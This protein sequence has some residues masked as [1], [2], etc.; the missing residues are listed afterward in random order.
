MSKRIKIGSEKAFLRQGVEIETV[1]TVSDLSFSAVDRAIGYYRDLCYPRLLSAF[2]LTHVILDPVTTQ[3]AQVNPE[4][5]EA[6]KIAAYLLSISPLFAFLVKLVFGIGAIFLIDYLYKDIE[7]RGFRIGVI[8]TVVFLIG[9]GGL[10][11]INNLL[12]G[13]RAV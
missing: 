9:V 3:F 7:H 1:S 11:S 4:S 6:N 5:I 12:L 13:L 8:V 2:F 10:V